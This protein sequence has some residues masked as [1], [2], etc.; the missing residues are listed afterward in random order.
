LERPRGVAESIR[1]VYLGTMKATKESNKVSKLEISRNGRSPKQGDALTEALR[2]LSTVKKETRDGSEQYQIIRALNW[3]GHSRHGAAAV[4]GT[5]NTGASTSRSI[6]PPRSRKPT[7]SYVNPK[8]AASSI[9]GAAASSKTR[10]PSGSV[11]VQEQRHIQSKTACDEKKN[12]ADKGSDWRVTHVTKPRAQKSASLPQH[13]SADSFFPA[14][15]TVS[16]HRD[17]RLPSSGKPSFV[18]DGD[19]CLPREDGFD[20]P[21]STPRPR[22]AHWGA[23][24]ADDLLADRDNLR[25]C[26]GAGSVGLLAVKKVDRDSGPMSRNRSYLDVPQPRPALSDI[27][28]QQQQLQSLSARSPSLSHSQNNDAVARTTTARRKDTAVYGNVM[29]EYDEREH[30]YVGTVHEESGD[31]EESLYEDVTRDYDKGKSEHVGIVYGNSGA[32]VQ[33]HDKDAMRGFVERERVYVGTMHRSNRVDDDDDAHESPHDDDGHGHVHGVTREYDGRVRGYVGTV[34][35]DS[36][37]DDDVHVSLKQLQDVANAEVE[38]LVEE[39]MQV[40]LCVCVCVCVCVCM[41]IMH[42]YMYECICM[43]VCMYEVEEL[44][45]EMMQVCLCV[46]MYVYYAC[47]YV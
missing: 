46:C 14:A 39:M 1:A 5:V 33:F 6:S 25:S 23:M 16:A 17:E 2:V 27:A 19:M 35:E 18:H 40:C 31:E 3:R 29:R 47:I 26:T 13:K 38:E 30:G 36:G 22:K 37:V 24:H 9:R 12:D 8:G 4:G 42:V 45:E 28:T 20:S 15:H 11:D 32:G 43:Y 21:Q 41:Y 7:T 10:V 34:H 44:V